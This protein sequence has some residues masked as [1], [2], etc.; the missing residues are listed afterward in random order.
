MVADAVCEGYAAFIGA[1][2]NATAA[3]NTRACPSSPRWDVSPFESEA[4]G[5]SCPESSP[6]R[7]VRCVAGGAEGDASTNATALREVPFGECE[8][9]AASGALVPTP[10]ADVPCGAP[11]RADASAWCDGA[12]DVC[13]FA[14]TC[15]ATLN[16]CVCDGGRAGPRC[17]MDEA[18][19]FFDGERI[20]SDDA[21]ECCPGVVDVAGACCHTQLG[22]A[23]L[24]GDG[25][26]C[27]SGAVD[28]CGACGGAAN[29]VDVTGKCCVGS[30][31]AGGFCCESGV[32]DACG[33]CD[34]TG[35]TCPVWLEMSVVVPEDVHDAG[36]DAVA[37]HLWE[38]A[39]LALNLSGALPA[40]ASAAYLDESARLSGTTS[41]ATS[42]MAPPPP[43]AQPPPPPNP[44][45][46]QAPS[47]PPPYAP[48]PPSGTNSTNSTNSTDSTDA[49]VGSDDDGGT[50]RRRLAQT[51]TAYYPVAA[52]FPV[53]ARRVATATTTRDGLIF[54]TSPIDFTAFV[55]ERL[56]QLE[57]R[58]NKAFERSDAP[59]AT[60]ALWNT[61]ARRVLGAARA[62]VCGDGFCEA[63]ESC[64]YGAVERTVVPG[65]VVADV[66]AA[67]ARVDAYDMEAVDRGITGWQESVRVVVEAHVE[68]GTGVLGPALARAAAACC[69]EDCPAPAACPAPEG[70]DEPCGG[71]GLCLPATG[72]CACFPNGGYTGAACGECAAGFARSRG[73]CVK[74]RR[75]AAPAP[76]APPPANATAAGGDASLDAA[77]PSAAALRALV[78][79]A[80]A[81]LCLCAFVTTCGGC[82]RLAS[83][84]LRAK[85]DAEDAEDELGGDEELGKG[86]FHARAD[87]LSRF[88]NHDQ[89][90][91]SPRRKARDAFPPAPVFEFR[92]ARAVQGGFIEEALGTAQGKWRAYVVD[93]SG[94]RRAVRD[95]DFLSGAEEEEEEEDSDDPRADSFAGEDAN[96]FFF[97]NG[98]RQ[99]GQH[100]H[101]AMTRGRKPSS[102]SGG[103]SETSSQKS[104]RR[105][106]AAPPDAANRPPFPSAGRAESFHVR[107]PET[108]DETRIA[109]HRAA[110]RDKDTKSRALASAG[111]EN[112]NE[113]ENAPRVASLA[114]AATQMLRAERVAAR[115]KRRLK[116]PTA[117]P[118]AALADWP[119]AENMSE[120][121]GS[122]AS[123]S[124]ADADVA[125]GAE[126]PA[127]G[128]AA[129]E[130]RRLEFG[131]GDVGDPVNVAPN[132]DAL[133]DVRD[134]HATRG[135]PT[136]QRGKRSAKPRGLH[137]AAR[138]GG[139]GSGANATR[140]V[141]R[142]PPG[143]FSSGEPP[144]AVGVRRGSRGD[145]EARVG[146]DEYESS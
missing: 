111:K 73:L 103:F 4:P 130:R 9:L 19:G 98:E 35:E 104:A 47:P 107:F 71:H 10:L 125:G 85:E 142:W 6:R 11:A 116:R 137:A 131:G 8:A 75:R 40:D 96:G 114:A 120:K 43:R 81:V 45:G 146:S 144:S 29:A 88:G 138:D 28:A 26:C 83:R 66:D 82:G 50:R 7:A 5:V 93:P 129:A 64:G 113:N 53:R 24:D 58:S 59:G 143:A 105:R 139:G 134:A 89:S 44:P 122:E 41:F 2:P 20:A 22:V 31:D 86:S 51:A 92:R 72:Q 123:D 30:L 32:F 48:S 117:A 91:T 141:G 145:D 77:D 115:L 69:P 36:D 61:R 140:H 110:G 12:D 136:A 79:V 57:Q 124:E 42:A 13:S 80:A 38:W 68:R 23:R 99:H 132:A 109:S 121:I 106:P 18:C 33:V 119:I 52:A 62:G 128:L 95:G 14:G 34:G 102:V 37:A 87:R 56:E 3:C 112:E 25:V 16:A 84:V 65:G 135:L 27:A 55:I 90:G 21:G 67:A 60:D 49:D 74:Q 76:P 127:R 94:A 70:S 46:V 133:S 108:R 97:R 17:E 101:W 78:G 63:G 15:D 118:V 126:T 39:E 100:G 54:E 1:A